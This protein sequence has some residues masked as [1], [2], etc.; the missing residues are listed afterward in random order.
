MSN[1]L[2]SLETAAA[3]SPSV[4]FQSGNPRDFV[5]KAGKRRRPL[6]AR[7]PMFCRTFVGRRGSRVLL[8]MQK[9]EGSNPFSRF[10]R[11]RR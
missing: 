5:V 6:P 2:R 3:E 4:R 1:R 10:T 11:I 7:K 9:V 8:A